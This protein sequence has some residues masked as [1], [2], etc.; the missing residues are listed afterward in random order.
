MEVKF[1]GQFD[2]IFELFMLPTAKM[3]TD[4][5]PVEAEVIGT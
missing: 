4:I 2:H 1:I 3:R 5:G